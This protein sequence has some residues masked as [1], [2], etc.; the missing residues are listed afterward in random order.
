MTWADS[1]HVPAAVVDAVDNGDGYPSATG[2]N[3]SRSAANLGPMATWISCAVCCSFGEASADAA[4]ATASPMDDRRMM[5][6]LGAP[7]MGV[8]RRDGGRRTAYEEAGDSRIATRK[9]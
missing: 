3:A 5:A 7:A 6:F 2:M 4:N 8:P 9:V 1:F